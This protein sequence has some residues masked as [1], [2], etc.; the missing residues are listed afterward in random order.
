VVLERFAQLGVAVVVIGIDPVHVH[1]VEPPGGPVAHLIAV[2]DLQ[3]LLGVLFI[4]QA[5]DVVPAGGLFVQ[6]GAR[7]GVGDRREKDH[8]ALEQ[9]SDQEGRC[10]T[11][12]DAHR[13]DPE[14]QPA[15]GPEEEHQI[16]R[17]DVPVA[18]L[19]HDGVL[20]KGAPK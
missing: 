6:Q 16:E 3:Q 12:H 1:Q 20:E 2:Q 15:P 9:R 10:Q 19:C 17:L 14:D 13:R 5:Q 18:C 7:S 8:L 4:A 11:R